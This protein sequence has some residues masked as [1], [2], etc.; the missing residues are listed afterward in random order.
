MV[1]SDLFPQA[2]LGRINQLVPFKPD[3]MKI[4]LRL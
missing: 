2:F 1:K 4:I 3:K